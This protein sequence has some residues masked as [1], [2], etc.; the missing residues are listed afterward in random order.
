MALRRAGRVY[1]LGQPSTQ[2]VWSSGTRPD[3]AGTVEEVAAALAPWAWQRLSVGAG[4]K[5]RAST[6]GRI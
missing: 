4:S 3:I 1:V 6:T 2:E 5:G